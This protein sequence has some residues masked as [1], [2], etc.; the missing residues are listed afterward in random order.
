MDDTARHVVV[1]PI[2]NESYLRYRRWVEA[3]RKFVDQ[4][5]DGRVGYIYVPNTGTNGQDELVRQ[6]WGNRDREALIVDE[7][8]NGGGQIPTRFIE[9]LNR[10]VANYWSLREGEDLVWPTSMH[11]SGPNAC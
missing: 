4:Q 2:G 3:N 7:R 1:E 10:P 6:F 5:T 9:L 8:W 11:T